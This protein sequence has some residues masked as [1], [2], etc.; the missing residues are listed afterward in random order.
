MTVDEMKEKKR[1]LGYSSEKLAKL[2]MMSCFACRLPCVVIIDRSCL[3]KSIEAI[4]TQGCGECN[5]LFL[6][7]FC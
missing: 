4:V 7:T 2:S 1:Q 3:I 6:H 5:V